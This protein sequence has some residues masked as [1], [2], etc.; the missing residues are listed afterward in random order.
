MESGFNE[1]NDLAMF[2]FL[3]FIANLSCSIICC[4]K[5]GCDYVTR[6]ACEHLYEAP[7][8]GLRP[9]HRAPAG[10]YLEKGKL[11]SFL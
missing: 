5:V 7:P 9:I 11:K 10:G 1:I 6:G 4:D 2:P 3:L 8:L